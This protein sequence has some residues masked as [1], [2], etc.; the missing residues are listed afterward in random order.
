MSL[1]QGRGSSTCPL[2]LPLSQAP[3][4]LLEALG[5]W[6]TG[7]RGLCLDPGVTK[8]FVRVQCQS[9]VAAPSIFTYHARIPLTLDP[10]A[11]CV[12]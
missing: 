11:L 9:V 12:F 1:Q 5:Q 4:Q 10:T 6:D 8:G 3:P 7:G 2:C